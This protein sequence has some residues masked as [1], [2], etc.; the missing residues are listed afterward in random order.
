MLNGQGRGDLQAGGTTNGQG[1]LVG[2]RY[3][4][5]SPVGRGGM[6]VVWHAHDVL[7]DRDVAVKELM[8][9]LGSD[10]AATAGAHRRVLRE[11]RAAARLS[12]PGIVTV[13]DVVEED[14]RPWIVMEYIRSWSLE[15]AVRQTGPLPVVQAAEIGIRILDALRHAHGSGILHRDVKPGNVLLT[16]DRVIL[17]DFG[18]AAAEGDVSITHS[19]LLMG[20]PSYIPP[21]RLRSED[22][23]SAADLWSFGATLYA[24]VEGRPPYDGSDVVAILGAIMAREPAP[25]RRAGA[26]EPILAGL[27]KKDPAERLTA[28]QAAEL[29]EQLL[30]TSVNRAGAAWIPTSADPVPI[31][32]LPPL[33]QVSGPQPY[34]I[35]ETPS[36]PVRIPVE[37]SPGQEGQEP[38][39]SPVGAGSGE[40]AGRPER[41]PSR[42]R[43]V[44]T[45]RTLSGRT[46]DVAVRW[47][48]APAAEVDG[49]ER[50]TGAHPVPDGPGS[51]GPTGRDHEVWFRDG[52]PTARLIF[53]GAGAVGFVA[54][55]LVTLL[56]GSTPAADPPRPPAASSVGLGQVAGPPSA[57][58][59]TVAPEGYTV[60]RFD[61]VSLIVPKGWTAVAAGGN[62][63]VNGPR[64]SGSS[65]RISRATPA[66][67]GGLGLLR[68]A[69]RESRLSEY[70]L[71]RLEA[72]A[73]RDR[74]SADWEYTFL[75]LNDEVMH[76]LERHVPVRDDRAYHVKITF[77]DVEW[78]GGSR[79][80]VATLFDS[81]ATTGD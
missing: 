78:N 24:A 77:T 8:L 65:I 9:P 53:A 2:R 79:Q 32:L 70:T 73:Y 47:P 39:A 80:I 6:G 57:Q 72:T 23:T 20:S 16:A 30:R 68:Q 3:R 46:H 26:M 15:Q 19:G 63:T 18:I 76:V 59:L 41:P 5:M 34:R 37:L 10:E 44:Q 69:D 75:N 54:V 38:L 36:G 42:P 71:L 56:S 48:T 45:G 66:G 7:L 31:H 28:E 22:I 52:R 21:E 55:V 1:R 49:P 11:A 12:H 29:L 67:D 61:G 33:E 64:H 43:R 13:H 58:A 74:P 14:G 17:T 51:D 25:P 35:V 60:K 50:T 40:P 81:F 4:L 27:L 62:L